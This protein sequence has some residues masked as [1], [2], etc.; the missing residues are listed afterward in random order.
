VVID[1]DLAAAYSLGTTLA[2]EYA[3]GEMVYALGESRCLTG[4]I[5][6]RWPAMADR[7]LPR[8]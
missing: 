5:G 4:R 2:L 6:P 3:L 8:R 1:G 7:P